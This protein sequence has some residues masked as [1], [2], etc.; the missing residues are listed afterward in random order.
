MGLPEGVSFLRSIIRL[1]TRRSSIL[2]GV[3]IVSWAHFSFLVIDITNLRVD[4][5]QIPE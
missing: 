5:K 2:R 4:A 1:L 3:E